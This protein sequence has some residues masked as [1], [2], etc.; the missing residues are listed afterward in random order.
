MLLDFEGN[1][2]EIVFLFEQDRHSV[3]LPEVGEMSFNF[4]SE[5][6]VDVL[7]FAHGTATDLLDE[8]KPALE[9]GLVILE[10][11]LS[12]GHHNT[13]KCVHHD[14]ED[15]HADNLNKT[16]DYLLGNTERVEV[17]VTDS[18]E[19]GEH[20]IHAQYQPV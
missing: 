11:V 15:G 17:S 3:M 20:I 8:V 9:V 1:R 14:R 19:R 16:S 6:D 5:A 7:A 18:R 10:R 2:V 13:D 4:G 12:A